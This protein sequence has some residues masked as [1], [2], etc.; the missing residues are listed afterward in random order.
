MLNGHNGDVP[1]QP[2][3]HVVEEPKTNVVQFAGALSGLGE[4]TLRGSQ[5]FLQTQQYHWHSVPLAGTDVKTCEHLVALEWKVFAFGRQ[6][7][8]RECGVVGGNC[9]TGSARGFADEDYHAFWQQLGVDG[10]Q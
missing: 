1:P 8:E 6:M 10:Q 4:S 2:V 9:S 7:E 5:I 3:L